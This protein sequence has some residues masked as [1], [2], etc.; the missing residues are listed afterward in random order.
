[1]LAGL[2]RSRKKA[3]LKSLAKTK[4]M[5]TNIAELIL[6]LP[7][8]GR[9]LGMTPK[10]VLWGVATVSAHFYIVIGAVRMDLA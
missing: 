1:M 5:M 4:R 2:P 7:N 8:V 10:D 3:L 6:R 9:L